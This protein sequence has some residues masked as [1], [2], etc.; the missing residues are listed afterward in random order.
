MKVEPGKFSSVMEFFTLAQRSGWRARELVPIM[1][2]A[3]E[4]PSEIQK[5]DFLSERE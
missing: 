1:R 5:R 2:E 4:M 3:S